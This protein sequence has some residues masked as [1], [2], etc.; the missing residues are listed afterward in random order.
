MASL[1]LGSSSCS[2]TSVGNLATRRQ[3]NYRKR[4]SEEQLKMI[5]EKNRLRAAQRRA[6]ETPEEKV[7][8]NL[9]E[10]AKAFMRRQ[11]ETAEEKLQRRTRER[12]HAA[13]K[14]KWETAEKREKRLQLGR[15]RASLRRHMESPESRER[16]LKRGRERIAL[17]RRLKKTGLDPNLL[18][19]KRF[20]ARPLF[21]D[22]A[23]SQPCH[24]AGQD[25]NNRQPDST[26]PP[27]L[28]SDKSPIRV[29]MWG[30]LYG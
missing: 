17:R 14:R 3:A 6:N 2:D 26:L 18:G 29:R 25:S 10:R 9:T 5:R 23:C 11:L 4:L 20:G 7:M 27:F 1:E 30:T 13:L 15:E 22:I 24:L 21:H 12:E 28:R 16:R 8:R 19:D